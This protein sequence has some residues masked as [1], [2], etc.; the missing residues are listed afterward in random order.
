MTLKSLGNPY[1]AGTGPQSR[2]AT[3]ECDRCPQQD[4]GTAG[5]TVAGQPTTDATAPLMA[6][7]QSS[8]TDDGAG[9][10]ECGG[11]PV[12]KQSDMSRRRFMQLLGA[13]RSPRRWQAYSR[14][15]RPRRR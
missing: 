5:L 2:G 7:P 4:Q 3:C 6:S 15:P 8:G 10:R 14:W 12:F 9:D 11:A 1:D 13:A